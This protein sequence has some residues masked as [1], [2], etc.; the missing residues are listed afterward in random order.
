MMAERRVGVMPSDEVTPSTSADVHNA[1][2]T[3]PPPVRKETTTGHESSLSPDSVFSCPQRQTNQPFSWIETEMRQT[4]PLEVNLVKPNEIVLKHLNGAN[5]NDETTIAVETATTRNS[6]LLAEQLELANSQLNRALS[7]RMELQEELTNLRRQH[8]CTL[9]D[10]EETMMERSSVLEENNRLA[11]ERDRLRDSVRHLSNT[12]HNMINSKTEHQIQQLQ[13]KLEHTR[14]LLQLNMEETACANSR[15]EEARQEMG[16][17]RVVCEALE[18]ER[19]EALFQLSNLDERDEEPMFDTWETHAPSPSANLGVIL[20]GGKGDEM[21]DVGMPIFVRDLVSGCPFDGHLKPLDYILCVNDIDVSSMD[22]RSV[23]DILSN[24]CNLKM[25]VKRRSAACRV[26]Q[27]SFNDISDLGAEFE[28]G[29]FISKVDEN[30]SGA[31]SGLMAGTRLIHVNGIPVYD[32]IQTKALIDANKGNVVLGVMS[33]R[34]NGSRRAVNKQPTS[35]APHQNKQRSRFLNKVHDKLFGRFGNEKS[36]AIIAHANLDA[37]AGELTSYRHGSLRIPPSRVSSMNHE[38]VR[39]GSLRA[40]SHSTDQRHINEQL[41]KFLHRH[42][43]SHDEDGSVRTWPKSREPLTS[44]ELQW[45]RKAVTRPSVLPAFPSA[46]NYRLR[47]NAGAVAQSDAVMHSGRYSMQG[48]TRPSSWNSSAPSSMCGASA[49]IVTSTNLLTQP[50][51]VGIAHAQRVSTRSPALPQPPPYPGPRSSVDSLSVASSNSYPLPPSS[52]TSYHRSFSPSGTILKGSDSQ[53]LEEDEEVRRVVVTRDGGGGFGL[54][55]DNANGGVVISNVYGSARGRVHVCG[56]NMRSA[57]KLAATRVL[58]QLCASDDEVTLLVRRRSEAPRWVR[59]PRRSIRLCG[60]N[61]IGVL[62]EIPVGELNMGERILEI[63]GKDMREATLEEATREL[64][65]GRSEMVDLMTEYDG[66]ERLKRLRKGADSDSFFMRVNIDRNG[67]NGDELDIKKGEIVYVDNTLFMG[68]SGRWRA[69]RVDHEGR[70]RQCG[71]IPSQWRVEEEEA[72]RQRRAKG[73]IC[74]PR[75]QRPIY[76]RVERVPSSQRRPLVLL[77]AY[78]APFMQT[79]ID[80]HSDKFAQCVPECRALNANE[81]ERV[82]ISGRWIEVRRREELF[83]VISVSALEHIIAQGYH[84]VLDVTPHTIVRLHS[85]RIYPIV[86]RIK[87]KSAKQLKELAEE[88]GNERISSKAAREMLE[89][90]DTV[91]SQLDA[92]ECTV[93]TIGVGTHRARNAVKYVCQQIVAIVEHEQK[94]TVWAPAI[95][96][97]RNGTS[98]CAS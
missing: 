93:S 48:T 65:N 38:L 31:E 58:Q 15:R 42:S 90:A 13:S 67:E 80:E 89:R 39:T 19:D 46:S 24:S 49:R 72:S 9:R 57:D 1:S 47:I 86:V 32:A 55:L 29:V 33:M 56:I 60:G 41:D 98:V 52:S 74:E 77:S 96:Q 16:R 62:V 76:E 81:G 8:E 14:R 18:K 3:I 12:L 75:A 43:Q 51:A 73:R 50:K 26:T 68:V 84:C 40:T 71:I 79:L 34:S 88:S 6:V 36:R 69:W 59:V 83:E 30:G 78:L 2:S 11:E 10:Y 37:C 85:L 91:D 82:T 95:K 20:G 4:R 94:R 17:M 53:L 97:P 28:D 44:D 27:F 22:Q 5:S 70:Q 61:A 23:V 25:V 66:G 7:A 64:E 21:F 92:L 54:V 45:K 35:T 63:D 87:F